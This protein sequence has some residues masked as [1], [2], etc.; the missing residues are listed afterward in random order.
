MKSLSIYIKLGSLA[1]SFLLLIFSSLSYSSEKEAGKWYEK[2]FEDI[3]NSRVVT[4]TRNESTL[5]NVPGVVTV[6]S[7]EEIQLMGLRSLKEV[8][9]RTTGFFVNR[10]FIGATVGSRKIFNYI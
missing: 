4:A 2:S 7:G 5:K 10:Q 3:L 1:S 8:L 9:E 6:F